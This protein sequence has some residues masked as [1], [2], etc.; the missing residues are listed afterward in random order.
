MIE[1]TDLRKQF[2]VR[3]SLL[4]TILS[5]F[6][7][8]KKVINAVN[9]LSFTMERGEMMGLAGE[10]G[11]GKTTTGM[12]LLHL[13][14]PTEGRI[15]FDKQDVT[16][17]SKSDLKR[18]RKQAQLIFQDPYESLNPRFTVLRALEEPLLIHGVRDRSAREQ[19]VFQTM[20]RV[21]L[22]P[23]SSFINKFPHEL[24]GGER[25]RVCIARAIIL[26]PLLLVADE[27]VSMLDVSI[28]ASILN[29]LRDLTD[30][31]QMATLYISH[32]LSL[33][34][35]ICEKVAIM[36][37]G[38]IVEMGR[39]DRVILSPLHPYSRALIAAVPVPEFG[40]R[41]STIQPLRGEPPNLISLPKGCLFE[42]RC[43]EARPICQSSRPTLKE[44]FPGHLVSCH[45]SGV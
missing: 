18:F 43:P 38:E 20:E 34:G 16:S 26:D 42:L 14:A 8:K 2:P 3:E 40:E 6:G 12:L 5:F 27:A 39:P 4:Q 10:S 41:S 29:L 37:A 45:I 33:L 1:V 32:D 35:S 24:S 22:L 21:K 11:C 19:K 13:Y 28:R 7:R 15:L 31:M 23:V 30:Q 25:Q 17:L 36:Y 9:G 44:V